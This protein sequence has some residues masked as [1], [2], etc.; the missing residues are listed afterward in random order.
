MCC[1]IFGISSEIRLKRG[2]ERTLTALVS[3]L[4][5]AAEGARRRQ[6][7]EKSSHKTPT[8]RDAAVR[9]HRSQHT[10]LSS[11]HRISQRTKKHRK[12]ANKQTDA[13]YRRYPL[14]AMRTQTYTHTHIHTHA[15]THTHTHTHHTHMPATVDILS[16]QL[17]KG[18]S[19]KR[20]RELRDTKEWILIASDNLLELRPGRVGAHTVQ[21][22]CVCVCV[23]VCACAC[24]CVRKS[25]IDDV[26]GKRIHQKKQQKNPPPV[27]QVCQ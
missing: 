15:H 22:W 14:P 16:W 18:D 8:T 3:N 23:R 7:G 27:A 4:T 6:N 13:T 12:R 19:A 1:C 24:A 5:I 9:G 21:R 10:S 11:W 20:G 25:A 17:A 2:V 26:N